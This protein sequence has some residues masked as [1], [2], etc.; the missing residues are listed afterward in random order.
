MR[1]PLDVGVDLVM[2]ERQGVEIDYCPTCRGVWLDRGELD[3]I[4]DRA[5]ELAPSPAPAGPAPRVPVHDPGAPSTGGYGVG[6][7]PPAGAYGD[8]DRRYARPDDRPRSDDPR[9]YDDDDRRRYGEDR[10][11]YERHGERGHDPRRKRKE[12]WLGDLLDFG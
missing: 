6:G 3:K 9:R 4:L 2:T 12:S 11:R 8:D 10:S 5:A 1:C 7:Y